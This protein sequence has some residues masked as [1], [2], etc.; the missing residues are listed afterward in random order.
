MTDA[1][2]D[3]SHIR[4]LLLTFFFRYMRPLIDLGY[5]YIAQPPLYKVKL[6]RTERYLKDDSELRGFLYDW[7]ANS[8]ELLLDGEKVAIAPWQTTLKAIRAYESEVERFGH[9]VEVS[10]SHTHELI[11]FADGMQ[12][13]P[14]A[15]TT[16]ELVAKLQ[17][18]F[19]RYVVMLTQEPV[20]AAPVDGVAVAVKEIIVF[21]E[22]KKT[23]E[24]PARFFHS[25]EIVVLLGL[26]ADVKHL[27][28]ASWQFAVQ[29]KDVS[30]EGK[31][32]LALCDAIVKT[33]KALMTIQ[34]YK[35]LG[36]MNPEQLWETTMDPARRTFVQVTIEDAIKADQWF[37]SLMGEEVE[38]R[39]S[40]IEKHAHFVRNLDV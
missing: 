31:G 21:K 6:G 40:Y 38:D 37:S 39:R 19:P 12:W 23:W 36:E 26:Y 29:G 11:N 28:K 35:G 4:I 32:A 5:L 16:E 18:H 10:S 14:G 27:D 8:A 30:V 1:D 22:H 9:A 34:R 13:I 2:V 20:S 33:A 24:V 25:E 15:L 17:A 3:G 7:A